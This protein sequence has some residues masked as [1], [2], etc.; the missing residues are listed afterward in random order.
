MWNISFYHAM[1]KVN[2][3]RRSSNICIFEFLALYPG[4]DPKVNIFGL[5]RDSE[6]DQK[7]KKSLKNPITRSE[8]FFLTLHTQA[9][10]RMKKT[11]TNSYIK[12]RFKAVR[13]CLISYPYHCAC[14]TVTC[15]YFKKNDLITTN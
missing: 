3:I 4:Q 13:K 6:R 1:T 12:L 11:T 10:F 7:P 2:T 9:K 14:K 15:P 5:F 8:N